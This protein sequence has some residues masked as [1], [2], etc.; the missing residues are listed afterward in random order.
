METTW[1][2]SDLEVLEGLEVIR[3]RPSMYVGALGAQGKL[4]IFKSVL[5][6]A[7]K[8]S[9]GLPHPLIYVHL[10]DDGQSFYVD[11]GGKGFP[12]EP[13]N[14]GEIVKTL[15]SRL[16]AGKHI[17]DAQN[18]IYGFWNANLAMINALSE[19]FEIGT[20]QSNGFCYTKFK[21]GKFDSQW[22]DEITNLNEPLVSSVKVKFDCEILGEEKLQIKDVI[23]DIAVK[24]HF[25]GVKF[26]V[27]K[28][29]PRN[30]IGVRVPV[31]KLLETS[32]LIFS[33]R[34]YFPESFLNVEIQISFGDN[35]SSIRSFMN[36]EEI[37]TEG[38]HANGLREAFK[39]YNYSALISMTQSEPSFES[40]PTNILIEP[41]IGE[42]VSSL[43]KELKALIWD[44]I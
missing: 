6:N 23:E 13:G 25:T 36:Y 27:L 15:C 30:P 4:K 16:Y 24:S 39:E 29:S 9:E 7:L 5:N 17:R 35:V 26:L 41:A 2:I 32:T 14:P 19:T 10:E 28:S 11:N 37:S 22:T 3:R 42:C 43:A 40:Y 1:Q 18:P 38:S 21:K 44:K 8:A 31:P 20:G 12:E 34:K 33:K